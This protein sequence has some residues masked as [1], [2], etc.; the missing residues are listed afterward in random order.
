MAKQRFDLIPFEAIGDIADVLEYGAQKYDA[1]NWTNGSS[2]ARLFAATCRHLFAWWRGEDRDPETGLSHL[3]HAGCNV[4]FLLEHQRHGWGDDDRFKGPTGQPFRKHDGIQGQQG[5]KPTLQDLQL[6]AQ[7]GD[8]P[9]PPVD[10]LHSS[11]AAVAA[12]LGWKLVRPE[13]R[14]RHPKR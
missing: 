9:V 13:N 2:W 3:A 4:L 11:A 12:E 8:D 10:P 7:Q 5:E 14:P 1:Y 6:P